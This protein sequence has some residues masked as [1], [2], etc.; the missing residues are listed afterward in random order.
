MKH[1]PT[2]AQFRKLHAE[3]R[4]LGISRE[5]FKRSTGCL[6]MLEWDRRTMTSRI[7]FLKHVRGLP[8]PERRKYGATR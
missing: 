8:Y 3:L 5:E 4:D 1:R 7:K 2:P 6:S